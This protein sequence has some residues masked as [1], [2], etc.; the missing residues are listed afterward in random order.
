[1]KRKRKIMTY[2]I[3]K[4]GFD[5]VSLKILTL[6]VF[7]RV[8]ASCRRLSNSFMFQDWMLELKCICIHQYSNK[9]TFTLAYVKNVHQIPNTRKEY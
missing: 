5:L 8:S 1:M 9:N 4:L 2:K 7:L 6:I 3:L